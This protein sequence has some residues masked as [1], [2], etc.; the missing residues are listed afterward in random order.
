[1]VCNGELQGVVSWG[2]GC[3]EKDHPGVYAKVRQA[4][5]RKWMESIRNW[6][7]RVDSAILDG[8]SSN[9]EITWSRLLP[10]F[11]YPESDPR[12]RKN[13]LV[14]RQLMRTVPKE[15]LIPFSFL[16][17]VTVRCLG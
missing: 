1:M 9:F 11:N 12:K 13:V 3:A 6:S 14:E 8:S 16:V 5:L 2:Y 4:I 7:S 10:C 15:E 17:D